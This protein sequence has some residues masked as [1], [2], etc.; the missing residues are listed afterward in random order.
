VV[1][2]DGARVVGRQVGRCPPAAGPGLPISRQGRDL[3]ESEDVLVSVA[4][5]GLTVKGGNGSSR[6]LGGL[7]L[8]QYE[9]PADHYRR[10]SRPRVTKRTGPSPRNSASRRP[11]QGSPG[12]RYADR[13][14]R[15]PGAKSSLRRLA[16]ASWPTPRCIISSPVPIH[17]HP[18]QTW[19]ASVCDLRVGKT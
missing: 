11:I 1:H 15:A 2:S 9:P 13:G 4:T 19:P 18:R 3:G 17:M 16:Q 14:P 8:T 10:R 12:L 5:T 7:W 6:P